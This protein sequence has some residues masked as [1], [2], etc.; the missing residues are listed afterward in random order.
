MRRLIAALMAICAVAGSLGAVVAVSP[1]SARQ[2]GKQRMPSITTGFLIGPTRHLGL[3][4][5]CGGGADAAATAEAQ[6]GESK[7]RAAQKKPG[8]AVS[9]LLNPASL[10]AKAPEVY[11]VKLTTT[12]GDFVV[13][14]T[15]AWAPLGAD[16]FYNLV[17]NKFYDS[18]SFFRVLPGFVAQFGIP[19]N[20][21]V[22]RAWAHAT[23]KD[24]P[25]TVSNLTGNLT[26]ATGGQ[27]PHSGSAERTNRAALPPQRH[28]GDLRLT[29][30]GRRPRLSGQ[31]EAQNGNSG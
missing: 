20:P 31:G 18:A 22:G 17:K 2:T 16:R 19:A 21:A 27:N 13:Q 6:A 3:L 26:F 11:K 29:R 5:D 30:G 24:D 10:K 9:A 12:R 23:I 28:Q 15:R 25:V 1:P 8:R 4:A 14:V 7:S